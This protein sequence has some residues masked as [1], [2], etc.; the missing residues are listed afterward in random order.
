MYK[1]PLNKKS[2][3]Y[4]KKGFLYIKRKNEEKKQIKGNVNLCITEMIHN[5]YWFFHIYDIRDIGIWGNKVQ[6]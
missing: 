1:C 6:L 2:N 4:T 5:K 3:I